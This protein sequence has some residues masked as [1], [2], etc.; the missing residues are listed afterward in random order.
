MTL[1]EVTEYND[2]AGCTDLGDGRIKMKLLHK[3][4]KK[5]NVQHDTNYYQQYVSK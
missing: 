1:G 2:N 3:Q 4:F 5:N